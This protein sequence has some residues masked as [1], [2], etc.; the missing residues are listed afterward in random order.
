MPAA[1][2]KEGKSKN[3]TRGQ[4]ITPTSR[5]GRSGLG[6]SLLPPSPFSFH[7]FGSE[8][9][10]C[11][12][13]LPHTGLFMKE[14]VQLGIGGMF[15]VAIVVFFAM[16]KIPLELF[17]SVITGGLVWLFKDIEHART[18]ERLK[19]RGDIND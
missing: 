15:A 10:W 17:M 4:D 7:V 5:G 12:G 9:N 1:K 3:E 18:L 2:R 13:V 14:K 11:Y 19:E 6:A 8:R 16:G